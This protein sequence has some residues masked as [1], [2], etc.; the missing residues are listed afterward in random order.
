MLLFLPFLMIL[1]LSYGHR[2]VVEQY[3]N[4]VLGKYAKMTTILVNLFA[5]YDNPA[6]SNAFPW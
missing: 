1:K 4:A 3:V 2:R 5:T 6:S